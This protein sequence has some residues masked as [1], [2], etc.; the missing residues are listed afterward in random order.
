MTFERC[1]IIGYP[2]NPEEIKPLTGSTLE[3][4]TEFVGKVKITLPAYQELLEGS[5]ERYIIAGICKDRTLKNEEPVLID[6]KFI[7]EGYKRLNPPIEFDEKCNHFLKYL[8][9]FGGKENREFE[10]NSTKHFPLAFADQEE[11]T[12]IV[13]QLKSDFYITIRK[14][15]QMGRG[16]ESQ[17]YMGVKMTSSGKDEAKKSLPKMPLFGLVSQEITTG[18]IEVDEKINHARQLFF[19]EIPTLDKMR[20][21]CETLSYVLEPLRDDLKSYFSQKDVSDFFQIVNTFDI[22]HNKDTT[23]NLIHEEQLEW[24]FYSLL[25]TINAYTKLKQQGK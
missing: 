21:A 19:N 1:A 25:N 4:E 23:K 16:R 3:Y 18:N 11:F 5:F 24:V 10:I 13:D 12:R 20:S 7:R 15:H 6:S 14:T 8:Y 17:I 2:L 22:R 9:Q